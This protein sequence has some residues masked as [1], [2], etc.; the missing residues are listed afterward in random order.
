MD[1]VS[2]T[3]PPDGSDAEDNF[4]ITFRVTEFVAK[5][6]DGR[7]LQHSKQDVEWQVNIRG[8]TLDKLK[9]RLRESISYGSCQEVHI[10]CE[11]K[12]LGGVN[13][14]IQND[15]ELLIAFMDR[16]ESKQLSVMA[17]VVDLSNIPSSAASQ[18][19]VISNVQNGD[20]ICNGDSSDV[21]AS[22]CT[23]AAPIHVLFIT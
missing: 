12:T 21:N 16:W 8:M 15:C 7:E 17:E 23:Q 14:R 1:S 4:K 19:S 18:C 9:S 13:S 6:D 20:N 10:F 3:P 5:L 2:S 22:Q 11:D